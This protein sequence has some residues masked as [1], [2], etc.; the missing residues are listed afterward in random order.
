MDPS[1]S[2]LLQSKFLVTR[3]AEEFLWVGG[4]VVAAPKWKMGGIGKSSDGTP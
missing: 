3:L 1:L 4:S 2:S